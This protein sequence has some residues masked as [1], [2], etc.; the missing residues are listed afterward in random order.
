M[1]YENEFKKRKIGY[2]V[3]IFIIFIGVIFTINLEGEQ[4][5][6]AKARIG[7][8]PTLGEL[9]QSELNKI[10][11]KIDLNMEIDNVQLIMNNFENTMKNEFMCSWETRYGS[12]SVLIEDGKV[13]SKD[14]SFYDLPSVVIDENKIDQ[15]SK[16]DL[17]KDVMDNFGTTINYR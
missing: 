12:I 17:L 8:E 14:I 16:G 13:V 1:K 11:Q 3:I 9:E 2:G 7:I 10:Y 5:L 4:L 15:L 6:N